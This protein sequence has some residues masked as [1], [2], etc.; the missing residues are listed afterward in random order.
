M[1][2]HPD[3]REFK[4]EEEHQA[5]LADLATEPEVEISNVANPL[6]GEQWKSVLAQYTIMEEEFLAQWLRGSG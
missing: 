5:Y 4:L 3:W 6:S 2:E 1:S